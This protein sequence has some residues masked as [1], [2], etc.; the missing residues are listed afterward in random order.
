MFKSTPSFR[1]IWIDVQ[2]AMPVTGFDHAA[3]L[4]QLADRNEY[5]VGVV[6][7][8]LAFIEVDGGEFRAQHLWRLGGCRVADFEVVAG[9]RE[10]AV[11]VVERAVHAEA[12]A[13]DAAGVLFF[14]GVEMRALLWRSARSLKRR[15]ARARALGWKGLA[16]RAPSGTS[17]WEKNL[18]L[19][20]S[21]FPAGD[22]ACRSR[23]FRFAVVAHLVVERVVAAGFQTEVELFA[24]AGCWRNWPKSLTVA[25]VASSMPISMIWRVMYWLP[26]E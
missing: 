14:G 17:T 18:A 25:Y 23:G 16:S 4:L 22:P 12:D 26:T 8:H 1:R 21:V 7:A 15:S 5:E 19:R 20:L 13:E 6:F 3:Q 24:V 11:R 10:E 9:Q 2:L